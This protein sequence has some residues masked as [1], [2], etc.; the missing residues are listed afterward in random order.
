MQIPVQTQPLLQFD[1]AKKALRKQGRLGLRIHT[2][3][4]EPLIPAQDLVEVTPLKSAPSV[5]D[6]IVFWQ[7]DRW[8]CHWVFHI[9]ALPSAEGKSIFLT[10]PLN[11]HGED[12]P[13]EEDQIL[14]KVVSHSIPFMTRLKLIFLSFTWKYR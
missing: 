1:S 14:G 3:S 6:I 2:P 11:Q 5:W 10:R 13:V 8:L 7:G 9:N 12:L 4:M